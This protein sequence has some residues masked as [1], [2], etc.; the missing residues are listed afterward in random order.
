MKKLHLNNINSWWRCKFG[1]LQKPDNVPDILR[2][3]LLI[4]DYYFS[5]RKLKNPKTRLLLL[6][7]DLD[8]YSILPLLVE[9]DANNSAVEDDGDDEKYAETAAVVG[10]KVDTISRTTVRYLRIREDTAKYLLNLDVHTAHY[11]P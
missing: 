6:R 1:N 4:F 10:Q 8:R 5:S 3:I 9:K 11:D 2:Q 7:V